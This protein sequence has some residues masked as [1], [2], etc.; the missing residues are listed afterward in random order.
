MA[1]SPSNILGRIEESILWK[2]PERALKIYQSL[3]KFLI[4]HY[5]LMNLRRT[6][7]L[8]SEHSRFYSEKFR[9]QSIHIGSI[10][11]PSEL[12]SIMTSEK[13]LITH[14]ADDFLCRRPDTAFETT[15]TTSKTPKCVFF[16]NREVEDAGRMGSAAL[17]NLGVRSTDRVASSFDYSF[18]V[19]GPA[20]KSGL[21]ILGAF[22]V[23]AGRIDPSDF[24]DRIKPYDC[25]VIV[26]DPGWLVR[27]SEVAEKKGSWPV[28]LMIAGGEN[29][30][31]ISRRYVEAVW[32][33]QLI[34]S[35]GQTE[36]F[37]MIGLECE[38]QEGYHINDMDLW[39]EIPVADQDGYGELV[40]TTLRRNVMP[41]IR[42]RSGDVTKLITEPCSCG[43]KSARLTKLKGR[44]DD[45][46]VTSVGN[47]TP[48]MFEQVIE[49]LSL[50]MQEW[51]IS[52]KQEMRRDLIEFRAEVSG[53]TSPEN[54]KKIL[55]SEMKSHMP[56]AYQGIESGMAGFRVEI[57]RS[58]S[59]K[60]GGRKV[61][62]I[63]DERDFS[64]SAAPEHVPAV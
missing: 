64:K 5:R 15:G 12:Y 18:W 61:K 35:Y 46:V 32:D 27:L 39:A 60:Q 43:M 63:L 20:L 38:Q 58:G 50:R 19:S 31:E 54:L 17:W 37:G 6:L 29:L 56:I 24:Y 8:V 9:E 14:P 42:Y 49:R 55:L 25:N 45:M 7:R 23:E 47:I 22:H 62:R 10:N 2:S 16:S 34:L 51:Q 26:A 30:T 1:A 3:P 59:L 13:D 33:T 57:C 53:R 21:I 28:K 41:L 52:I 36:A 4:D 48:W 44:L 11:K 40:Y